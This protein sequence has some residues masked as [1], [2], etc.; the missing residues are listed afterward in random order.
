MQKVFLQKRILGLGKVKQAIRRSAGNNK[1]WIQTMMHEKNSRRTV[2]RARLE[3]GKQTNI[4][5]ER[6]LWR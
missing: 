1:F 2:A 3:F 4:S 5:R 6:I